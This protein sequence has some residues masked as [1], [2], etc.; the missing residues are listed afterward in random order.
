MCK[1]REGKK[2]CIWWNK[3]G[4]KCVNPNILIQPDASCQAEM[5]EAK[6]GG[7]YRVAG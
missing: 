4:N 3:E 1:L 7:Y 6:D 2:Q 5:P